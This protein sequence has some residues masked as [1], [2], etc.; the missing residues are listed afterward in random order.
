MSTTFN[1]LSQAELLQELEELRTR[2]QELE[3]EVATL[4]RREMSLQEA[5]AK[6]ETLVRYFP[7]VTYVAA[8]DD[9]STTIYV[10]PQ[11]QKMI[12]FT[13]DEYKQDPDIWLKQVHPEDRNR[14][15]EELKES[16][17]QHT[18]FKSEY[19]MQ[20]RN[21]DVVWVHDEAV[22]VHDKFGEPLCLQGVML[23]INE[24][25]HA[26]VRLLEYQQSLEDKAQERTAELQKINAQLT[27]EIEERR[28]VEL[29]LARTNE[30][31]SLLLENMP[32]VPY[33]CKAEGDFGATY[34]S[35]NI[36]SLTGFYPEDFTSNSSFWASRIHP[37]DQERLF[38]G[39]SNLFEHGYHEHEY[40]WQVKDGSYI[41]FS[42]YLRL[43]HQ[44]NEPTHI[45]G[46]WKDVT[47]RKQ[48]IEELRSTQAQLV[49]SA[50]LASLGEMATGIAH[51]I[52]QPLQAING[53]ADVGALDCEI[54]DYASIPEYFENIASCVAKAAEI[55]N[56][57]RTFGRDSKLHKRQRCNLVQVVHNAL[58]FFNQQ[59]RSRGIDLILSLPNHPILIECN[60]IQIE[61]VLINLLNNAKDAADLGEEKQISVRLLQEQ[62]LC[63][64]EV[65]DNGP[66]IASE[67]VSKVFDPFYTTKEVGKGTGLGL[68]IS[69]SIV[70]EHGG[71]LSVQSSRNPTLFR[72]ELPAADSP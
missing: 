66:G 21:G 25:K 50:K 64:L 44:E 51:E 68:S 33:T 32:V 72:I 70:E 12:G 58:K 36:T 46:V 69:I 41:W 22:V 67:A 39:L 59:L 56:H 34:M 37:D 61:Q 20:T 19:R 43:V 23:D 63:C 11:I 4:T 18:P 35:P 62:S 15:M 31:L 42:D 54:Q 5:E 24:K 60:E 3:T 71:T 8:L 28:Q 49:Q 65:E 26:E 27:S 1:S 17:N 13:P 47:E 55:T 40:R 14:V 10:S 9:S 53:Y 6:Y 45:S 38:Q 52:N 7:A 30:Q 29:T 2:N 16:H 57:L 48:V